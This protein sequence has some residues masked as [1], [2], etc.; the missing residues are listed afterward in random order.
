MELL[1]TMHKTVSSRPHHLQALTTRS[2]MRWTQVIASGHQPFLMLSMG[3][4]IQVRSITWI[5]GV[6]VRLSRLVGARKQVAVLG[7]SS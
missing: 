4:Q 6:Q 3:T 2:Y 7:F 5:S 1:L